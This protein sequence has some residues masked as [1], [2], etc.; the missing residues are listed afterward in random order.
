M[1]WN[2]SQNSTTEIL[3]GLNN[4]LELGILM[5]TGLLLPLVS[6]YLC[7]NANQ[8]YY[9]FKNR[10]FPLCFT[11]LDLYVD[12]LLFLNVRISTTIRSTGLTL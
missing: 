5:S 7:K 4:Q 3:L 12:G 8:V 1:Y 11:W 9:L 6:A 2:I 10:P